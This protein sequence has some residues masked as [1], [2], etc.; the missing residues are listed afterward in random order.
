MDWRLWIKAKEKGLKCCISPDAH[1]V[2]ELMNC[3][4]GINIARKGWL[5][6]E[7]VINTYSLKEMKKYLKSRL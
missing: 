4:Y 1:S 2:K 7:D 3:Q 5:E 6:K